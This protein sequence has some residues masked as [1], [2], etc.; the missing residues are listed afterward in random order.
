MTKMFKK[1][2]LIVLILISLMLTGC[3]R[4]TVFDAAEAGDKAAV[5]LALQ[6]NPSLIQAKDA[7]GYMLLHRAAAG[8]Q[9]ELVVMLLGRGVPVDVRSY[10]NN[11]GPTALQLAAAKGNLD[12][13]R[14]LVE[15]GADVNATSSRR[16]SFYTPLT[17]AVMKGHMEVIT[18]LISKGAVVKSETKNLY[19]PLFHSIILGRFEIVKLLIA[20]GVE[21]N[22]VMQGGKTALQLAVSYEREEI[23]KL[24]LAHGADV[25]QM[26]NTGETALHMLDQWDIEHPDLLLVLLQKG[27]LVNAA[28]QDGTTPLHGAAYKNF[29]KIT[30][31]LLEHGAD[32]N[33]RDS[34][35][36]TPLLIAIRRGSSGVKRQLLALHR[37]AAEGDVATVTNL[38]KT[39]GQLIGSRDESGKTALHYAAEHNRLDIA[40]IL[41]RAGVEINAKMEFKQISLLHGVIGKLL[42]PQNGRVKRIHDNITALTLAQQHDY[43]EMA[44]FLKNNGAQ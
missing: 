20:Q 23:A 36:E 2:I 5:L 41:L 3:S 13:V 10:Y 30:R 6:K 25:N 31:I 34:M 40:G 11:V 44:L 24:L 22:G 7:N 14:Y 15:K 16:D 43:Q 32:V 33:N 1:I 19:N 29:A 18:F 42:V 26:D 4:K 9:K 28:A 21:V 8:G 12:L 37:A 38:L 35:G 17:Y 27:A 39:C